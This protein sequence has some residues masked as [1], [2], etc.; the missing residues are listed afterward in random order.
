MISISVNYSRTFSFLVF[1]GGYKMETFA[2]N[3]LKLIQKASV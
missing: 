1:L 3:G 2:T